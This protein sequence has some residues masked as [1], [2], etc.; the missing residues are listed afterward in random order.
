MSTLSLFDAALEQPDAPALLHGDQVLSF[1][2]LAAQA[3]PLA[4][5]LQRRRPPVLQLTPRADVPS[6]LWLYA[7]FATATPV[8]TLHARATAAEAAQLSGRLGAI[9]PDASWL[10]P[11]RAAPSP[12]GGRRAA[13]LEPDPALPL[14]FIPTSGSTGEPRLVELSRRA[15]TASAQASAANLGW[16]PDDRWLLCLPLAHTGGLSIVA[17]CLLARR[18]VVLFDAGTGG[19]LARTRE[20][21][22]LAEQASLISLVPSLLDALLDAGFRGHGRLR[23]LLLGGSGCSPALARR[24]RA[25]ALPLLTSYGLTETASQVVTRRYAERFEPLAE[26]AGC[27]SSGHPLPGVELRLQGGLIAL[28]AP[29]LFTRY[30][31]AAPPA[32][33]DDGW[34]L[35]SDRGQLSSSGELFV[36]GRADDLIVTAGE[37]VDPVEVEAA[38]RELPGVREACVF[39]T[40]SER[41]GHVV[42]AALVTDD[43]ALAEPEAL[44]RLLADR[45][46]RHKWP[47]RVLRVETLPLTASGKLDRRRCAE[48]WASSFQA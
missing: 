32:E 47:R 14:V 29:S 41:F 12:P 13:A 39:G 17:R 34:L 2:E 7:A 8:L 45:L 27:V 23:A 3:E 38:L 43:A 30:A 1:G 4:A 48:S 11:G 46:A 28:R 16:E 37:N 40:I 19:A 31:G 18:P 26:H 24:A 6:L 9:P 5:A 25:A 20:L 42:T 22:P 15:V 36:L 35:T 44:G 33:L 21:L 10:E